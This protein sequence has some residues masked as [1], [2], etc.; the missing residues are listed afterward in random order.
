[1]HLPAGREREENFANFQPDGSAWARFSTSGDIQLPK[2]EQ[3]GDH[4]FSSVAKD[5]DSLCSKYGF[6]GEMDRMT[7]VDGV[8][9]LALKSDMN[10]DPHSVRT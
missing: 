10:T 3:A 4:T 2:P 7:L 9:I 1:M 6:V 8:Y 5:V